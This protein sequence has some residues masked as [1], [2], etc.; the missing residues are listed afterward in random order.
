L[1][2][3]LLLSAI[4]SQITL[5]PSGAINWRRKC[6]SVSC[7]LMEEKRVRRPAP[8]EMPKPKV[9]VEKK[10]VEQPVQVAKV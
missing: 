7:A 8:V 4:L 1:L 10:P 9:R 5:P 2:L 6:R 3:T